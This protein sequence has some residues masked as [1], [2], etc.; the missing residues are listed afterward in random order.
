MNPQRDTIQIITPSLLRA[1]HFGFVLESGV[2]CII[3]Q[4]ENAKIPAAAMNICAG[5]LNDPEHLPGLAHFCEHMLFNGT[6]RYPGEDEF[7]A[8]IAKNGGHH[9]AWTAA[10]A[11]TYY[12]TVAQDALEGALERF[13][14]FFVAPSFTPSALSREVKAVHSED[15]KNHSVDP[16]RI[17]ELER[18]LFD[19]RHPRHRYG[20]G[21]ITTLWEE[22]R[23][24]NVDIRV[25][26]LKF[27]ETYYVSEAACLAVYSAL[28]PETVLRII[29]APLAKMRVGATSPQ[30]FLPLED[31]LFAPETRGLWLN[32]RSLTRMRTLRVLWPV[33]SSATLWRSMPSKYVS[34]VLG[35]ECGSSVI[36]VLRREHL[37]TAMVVGPNQ[38]DD[39]HD[40]LYVDIEL[41]MHGFRRILDVIG[42]LYQGIGQAARVD[43][44]VYAQMKAEDKLTFES[45]DISNAVD[46]CV[47]LTDSA[48]KTDLPH[49]W[50]A[51]EMLLTDDIAAAEA[52]AAQL[53]PENGIVM[54]VWGDMPCDDAE[55]SFDSANEEKDTDEDD[56][57]KAQ[58][59]ESEEEASSE[60]KLD[61]FHSL[62]EF[63]QVACNS[64]TRFH[65]A[66]F[67]RCR[68]PTEVLAGWAAN[69]RGPW[70]PA[71]A[72]PPTNPFLAT[73]FTL[74]VSDGSH[75]TVDKFYTPY[76]VTLV[77]RDAGRHRSFKTSILWNW[78]SPCSYASPKNRYYM[79]VL[80]SILSD[81]L[82]EMSYVGMLA[83]IKN[84][85]ELHTGG[86]LF[87]ATGPQHRI[88]E[89]AL[90][91]LEKS[92]TLTILS[93]SVERYDNYAEMELRKLQSLK[94]RQP[95]MMAGDR[96]RKAACVMLYTFEE[97][98]EAAAYASY[99]DY[100]AFVREYLAS[101]VFLEC[102]V[103]GNVPSVEYVQHHLIEGAQE[104]L[105]R[106]HVP[107]ACRESIPQYRD[108][109]AF[110][111]VSPPLPDPLV[112]VLTYPPFDATNPNVAVLFDIYL[113][114][115]T[116][117]LRALSDCTGQ[118]ISSSFFAAL[119]T[120]EALGY[121]VFSASLRLEGTAHLQFVAQSAVEGVN[122]VYLLSRVIA[123]LAAVEE[124]LEVVCEEAEVKT[125][126][127]GLI[128][129][130]RRLPNS[131]EDDAADLL[132]RH[133]HPVDF[134]YKELE[135]EELKQL[136]AAKVKDF[137][138]THVSNS[139]TV[140]RALAVVVHSAATVENDALDAANGKC[141]TLV[142]PPRRPDEG[143]VEKDGGPTEFILQLP[144]FV[145]APM[146]I[147]VKKHVSPEEFHRDFTVVRGK[148]F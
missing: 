106:L 147:A 70:H 124:G 73:D 10:G 34:H 105:S 68:I 90:A 131:V 11:T 133:L 118:L 15:E 18:T 61:L 94:S 144:D 2:K 74:H 23:A 53:T 128:E 108:T 89:F 12:F 127:N 26:L 84:E 28:P 52:Y 85:I 95:Y 102:C 125:V 8:Y 81:A 76:G 97:L 24:K 67:V 48:N 117:L 134:T 55:A 135:I 71:L 27:F 5:Q 148:P 25:E 44:A 137:F 49:C 114:E 92:F 6:A 120:R 130:R 14:E 93:A 50:I 88:V 99:A 100:Q 110:P 58:E 79:R 146:S 87:R 126:V 103:A 138:R 72:L 54:L 22:P 4:D 42:I 64:T 47:A 17:D 21:N 141:H 31:L 83:A 16:W 39:D 43:S 75:A 56:C 1:R 123:F 65:K 78:I 116:P 136:D 101:G 91:I 46:H 145:A 142:L 69:R 139:S 37:A 113:G 104:L 80:K 77:R 59:E 57:E 86:L 36:G 119:R 30:C 111:L 9:N 129:R 32:I 35:H 63:A 115:E 29:E 3:I 66:K 112:D 143:G 98:I 7:D 40:V 41:T 51:R 132:N 33:K 109:Y 96:F 107:P 60:A 140:R 45:S 19:P 38:V 82:A 121:V 20:S 122:G 13:V 62:P